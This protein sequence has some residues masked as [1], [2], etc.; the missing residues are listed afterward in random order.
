MARKK[1][2]DEAANPASA[3]PN[4]NCV[5][6]PVVRSW[7]PPRLPLPPPPP[8]SPAKAVKGE[9]GE[10]G[11]GEGGEGGDGDGDS[12]ADLLP[13]VPTKGSAPSADAHAAEPPSSPGA[14]EPAGV[15]GKVKNVFASPWKKGK[16]DKGEGKAKSSGSS[17]PS[18][19]DKSGGGG[20]ELKEEQEEEE[21]VHDMEGDVR[22]ETRRDPKYV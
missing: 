13:S 18:I 8:K 15:L 4:S 21:E 11:E 16:K 17:L 7:Q 12:Q 1:A 9:G 22:M 20:E 5:E 6:P 19:G 3:I 10:G 2:E 14:G